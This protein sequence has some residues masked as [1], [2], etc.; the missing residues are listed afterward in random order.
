M[1]RIVV[2]FSVV[3]L[4]FALCSC[5][6]TDWDFD[7]INGYSIYRINSHDVKLKD[8]EGVVISNFFVTSF[9]IHEPYICIKGIETK[10]WYGATEEEIRA[11]VTV[12]YLI[13]TETDELT[14][15]YENEEEFRVYCKE[16]GITMDELWMPASYKVSEQFKEV[17]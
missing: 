4:V 15:P 11:R 9:Q 3:I 2:L 7:L 16:T 17:S 12:C 6:A 5:G 13:N 10:E 8:E 14:G 1:K